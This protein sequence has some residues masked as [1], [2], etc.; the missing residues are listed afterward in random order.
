[1]EITGLQRL[2]HVVNLFEAIGH[3]VINDDVIFEE[4]L[5]EVSR[6][7]EINEGLDALRW[8]FQPT[9]AVSLLFTYSA[10]EGV[11]GIQP[12]RR[13]LELI[14]VPERF[15][16]SLAFIRVAVTEEDL[17]AFRG[18]RRLLRLIINRSLRRHFLA[19]FV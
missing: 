15:E 7:F 13:F 6:A 19:W 2:D 11:R 16:K 12:L 1:M 9:T 14:T 17:L 10:S 4:L 18:R 5:A 3:E 8:L